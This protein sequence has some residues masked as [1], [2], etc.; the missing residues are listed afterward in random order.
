M[1]KKGEPSPTDGDH[2]FSD[3]LDAA[4]AEVELTN[5]EFASLL[6]M[7]G[8]QLVHN[9]RRRGRIGAESMPAVR[10]ALPGISLDWLNS[11]VGSMKERPPLEPEAI[12]DAYIAIVRRFDRAGIHYDVAMDPDLLAL[13]IEFVMEPCVDRKVAF[14]RAVTSRIHRRTHHLPAPSPRPPGR[15][16][17]AH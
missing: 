12:A 2:N 15:R 4:L 16:D 6:G 10:D 7:N 5:A 13:G 8:H 1:F 3:R 9:W 17:K 14:E 11:G